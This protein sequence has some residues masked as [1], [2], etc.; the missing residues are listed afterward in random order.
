[1]HISA[2]MNLVASTFGAEDNSNA[3]WA[4]IHSV[5]IVCILAKDSVRSKPAM[6]KRIRAK[7]FSIYKIGKNYRKS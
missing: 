2:S 3:L 1:M 4:R 7:I 6:F 5:Q